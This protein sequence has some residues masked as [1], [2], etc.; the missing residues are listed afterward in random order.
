MTR[1]NAQRRLLP[2]AAVVVVLSLLS[3]S[4]AEKAA[5]ETPLTEAGQKLFAQY[6]DMLKG[7]AAEVSKSLPVAD[8]RKKAAFQEAR[9]AVK[10]A[11]AEA[12]AAQQPLNKIQ[13]ARA[14]VDHAKGK[15]I[16]GAE[17]G[18]AQAEAALSRHPAEDGGTGC[19]NRG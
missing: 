4:A 2:L 9:E 13:T 3:A 14:L 10:K 8:E 12:N 5:P 17:K 1:V 18:I 16:G 19:W 6:A 15:W 11:T 7:L